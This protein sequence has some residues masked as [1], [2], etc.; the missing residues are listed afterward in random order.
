VAQPFAWGILA[1]SLLPKDFEHA[2]TSAQFVT[3]RLSTKLG[4]E[5]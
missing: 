2:Q 4:R 1:R 5:H 3:L